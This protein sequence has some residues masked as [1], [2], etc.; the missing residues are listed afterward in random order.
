MATGTCMHV[1][2][3]K[4]VGLLYLGQVTLVEQSKAVRNAANA[5]IADS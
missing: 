5:D 1:Q 3:G 2:Q 4:S